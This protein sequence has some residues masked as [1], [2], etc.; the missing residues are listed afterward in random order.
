MCLSSVCVCVCVRASASA[1]VCVFARA[2]GCEL[3]G[4]AR[5]YSMSELKTLTAKKL[6]K[7]KDKLATMLR[8]NV[9]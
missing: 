3:T 1:C 7:K 9:N 4:F 6:S 2:G 5:P 8:M